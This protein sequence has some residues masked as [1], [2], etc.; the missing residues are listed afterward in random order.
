MESIRSADMLP[1][2]RWQ[3]A[4]NKSPRKASAPVRP[5]TPSAFGAKTGRG[6]NAAKNRIPK[7]KLEAE[8]AVESMLEVGNVAGAI[9]FAEGIMRRLE[10]GCVATCPKEAEALQEEAEGS[11]DV[12]WARYKNDQTPARRQAWRRSAHALIAATMAKLAA[13]I[14]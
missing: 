1:T 11:E 10:L 7:A 6:R 3:V 14:Q 8:A 9:G 4:P 2:L 5:T 12:M 13:E